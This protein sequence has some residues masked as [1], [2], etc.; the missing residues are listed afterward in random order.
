MPEQNNEFECKHL[1]YSIASLKPDWAK[2]GMACK[3]GAWRWRL[4]DRDVRVGQDG[5][6]VGWDSDDNSVMSLTLGQEYDYPE[7]AVLAK[8]VANGPDFT[9]EVTLGALLLGLT[10]YA[11]GVSHTSGGYTVE[12]DKGWGFTLS[13]TQRSTRAAAILHAVVVFLME[14]LRKTPPQPDSEN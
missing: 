6:W 9:D 7:A 11:I 4:S 3:E 13:G 1:S 12:W 14:G 5:W 2:P 8:A 10:P